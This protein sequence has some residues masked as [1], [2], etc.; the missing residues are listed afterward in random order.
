M[1]QPFPIPIRYKLLLVAALVPLVAIAMLLMMFS[2]QWRQQVIED[3]QKEAS[4]LASTST[5]QIDGDAF[6]RA[7]FNSETSPEYG[8]LRVM[9]RRISEPTK[10]RLF[11][12]ARWANELRYA[13]TTIDPP[14]IGQV[15]PNRTLVQDVIQRDKVTVIDLYSDDT[16]AWVS[17]YAPIH[18]SA[19]AVVGVLQVELPADV[20]FERY[21]RVM[22]LNSMIGLLALVASSLF[23]LYE[24]HR[25]V[26]R[27]MQMVQKGLHALLRHDF[28]QRVDLQTRD[29]F[30]ELGNS[31]NDIT[32]SLNVASIIQA[33]FFPR[34]L[35]P[36][37]GYRMAA[38]WLP[39]DA[40]G[41]DYF[42]AFNLGDGRLAVLLADVSG[43]GLGASLLM[44][45]CRSTVRALASTNLTPI[46][47][48]E[49]LDALLRDDLDSG[50]FITMIFGIL[51]DEGRFTYYN[52]GH[53]PAILV[54][55]TGCTEIKAQRPPV[56]VTVAG[57][58]PNDPE[59]SVMMLPGDRLLLASDGL[60]EARNATGALLG[61]EPVEAV[62]VNKKLSCEDVVDQL[63]KTVAKHCDGPSRSDDVTILCVE[64]TGG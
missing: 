28:N 54:N 11:T 29:E 44:S 48:I 2:L 34:E 32:V 20:Y 51:D 33:N 18:N 58:P 59:K 1:R 21:R 43:H 56:G 61:I 52:A 24:L 36:H 22:L 13:A 19:A 39:C 6:A 49:R 46:E 45:A 10:A 14:L 12:Y 27:P 16:G 41:G 47:L 15:A 37:R 17:A 23:A 63:C 25:L 38:R 50:R 64:R 8:Q 31:L 55:A 26:I 3:L 4:A 62:I 9:L 40:T 57:A 53:G 7:D 35:P 60:P 42:D 5:M 30:E